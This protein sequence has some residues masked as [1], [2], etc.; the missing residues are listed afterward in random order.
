MSKVLSASKD[1]KLTASP[2]TVFDKSNLLYNA[3]IGEG[4]FGTVYSALFVKLKR[5]S[6]KSCHFNFNIL[7]V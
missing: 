4:G 3:V 7:F 5:F 6:K 1:S 2:N